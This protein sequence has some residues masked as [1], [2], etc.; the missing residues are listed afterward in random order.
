MHQKHNFQ[1]FKKFLLFF[2]ENLAFSH[3]G[4]NSRSKI[5]LF[6]YEIKVQNFLAFPQELRYNFPL[7]AGIEKGGKTTYQ[8]LNGAFP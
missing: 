1:I 7:P 2:E 8:S 4:P 6:W 3:F 5:S